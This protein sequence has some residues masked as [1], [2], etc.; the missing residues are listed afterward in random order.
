MGKKD[1]DVRVDIDSIGGHVCDADCPTT[2]LRKL[3]KEWSRRL[4]NGF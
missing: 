1:G 2:D 4:N 3:S